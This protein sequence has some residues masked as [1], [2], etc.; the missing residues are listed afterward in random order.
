M[1]LVKTR[2][3]PSAIHGIGLFAD[4]F[5]PKGTIIWEFTHGYD[6]YVTPEQI[7]VLPAAAQASLLKYCHRDDLSGDY[8][9]CADDARFFNHADQPNTV[10][11]PGPEGETVAARDI[12]IGE[13]LTCDYWAFD[14]DAAFKLRSERPG[15][16]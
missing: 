7:R 4:E 10:D 12:A 14:A 2:I 8:V 16:R 13:E 5:I 6:V 3:A 11:L 15:R 1:L 9:L